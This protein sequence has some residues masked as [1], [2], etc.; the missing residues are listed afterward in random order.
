VLLVKF[1]YSAVLA[2]VIIVEGFQL[3]A[4]LPPGPDAAAQ[5]SLGQNWPNPFYTLTKIPYGVETPGR[6]AI[7]VYNTQ[8]QKV[9]TL[10][11]RIHNPGRY[12]AS[13]DGRTDAGLPSAPGMYYYGMSLGGA[14]QSRK[15]MLLR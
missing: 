6:V 8:G 1:D 14:R 4:G 15:L 3:V 11:D 12:H 9:A 10:I 2:S 13:W 5:I 7:H